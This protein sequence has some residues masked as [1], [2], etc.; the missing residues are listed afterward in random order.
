MLE[1]FK[2]LPT[3]AVSFALLVLCWF[4]HF[5]FHRRF[6]LE[7][8]L[9]ITLNSVFLFVLLFYVYPLKFVFTRLFDMT[10]FGGEAFDREHS[11]L[12]MVIYSS[13]YVLVFLLF[14]VMHVHAYRQR[15]AL[16]LNPTECQVTRGAIRE[17]LIHVFVGSVSIA[18]ALI[19]P[20][21]GVTLAGFVYFLLGPLQGL[22]GY[23]NGRRVERLDA[24]H[25]FPDGQAVQLR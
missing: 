12:L 13:A 20:V 15:D 24:L 14:T 1:S 25:P 17:H 19:D 8:P 2:Q 18:C 7:G 4:Y 6:G 5:K 9:T 3:F 11:A 16:Q 21:W 23:W 22:H 10:L